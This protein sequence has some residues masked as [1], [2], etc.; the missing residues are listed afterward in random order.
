MVPNRFKTAIVLLTLAPISAGLGL[1]LIFPVQV[2]V[3]PD[4]FNITGLAETGA[5]VVLFALA[6]PFFF[7]GLGL[8]MSRN[9]AEAQRWIRWLGRL[10]RKWTSDSQDSTSQEILSRTPLIILLV[11]LIQ[12]ILLLP[13][14]GEDRVFPLNQF[15][16]LFLSLWYFYVLSILLGSLLLI[17]LR[18]LG[19]YVLGIMLC[20]LSVGT[21]VPDVLGFLPPSAPTIRTALLELSVLPPDFLLAYI[22]WKTIRNHI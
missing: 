3:A 12:A 2:M 16:G 7:S 5:G 15:W 11:I 4:V 17:Y 9:G 21:S 1:W 10:A 13:G 14:I 18:R 20:V 19:G 8:F 22:S 6:L